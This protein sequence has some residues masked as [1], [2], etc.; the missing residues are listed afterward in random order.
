MTNKT[1]FPNDN[2]LCF[3]GMR[4]NRYDSLSHWL[5]MTQRLEV[6]HLWFVWKA[7]AMLKDG[8]TRVK[9]QIWAL[10]NSFWQQRCG[11]LQL[12][13]STIRND[14]R[15]KSPHFP[16][17]IGKNIKSTLEGC[18]FGSVRCL[19]LD[20]II[21]HEST[22]DCIWSWNFPFLYKCTESFK[23]WTLDLLKKAAWSDDWINISCRAIWRSK[24]TALSVSFST[25]QDT[26]KVS[27]VVVVSS[28]ISLCHCN[29]QTLF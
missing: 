5:K 18:L 20:S 7:E 8:L 15:V 4:I 17:F 11:I 19:K 22:R 1:L 6:G 26:K 21:G 14:P 27:T 29:V 12:V 24:S 9:K 25:V 13:E 3:A 10:G 23:D 16:N 2:A 28:N